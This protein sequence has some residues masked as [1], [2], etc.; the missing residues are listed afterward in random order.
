VGDSVRQ[1]GRQCQAGRETET[2]GGRARER[3]GERDA[4][5]NFSFTPVIL[6][7][8]SLSDMQ[9]VKERASGAVPVRRARNG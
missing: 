5:L 1:G 4:L 2:E 9:R 3:K 6:S 8:L 7:P